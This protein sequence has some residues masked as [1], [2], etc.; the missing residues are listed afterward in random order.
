L[1]GCSEPPTSSDKP[2]ANVP[3][4]VSTYIELYCNDKLA[5]PVRAAALAV[6]RLYVPGYPGICSLSG[7]FTGAFARSV[8][9]LSVPADI[10]LQG[11]INDVLSN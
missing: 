11:Q 7:F 2:A 9:E 1:F 5:D 10:R 6:I 4:K 3:A 8:P